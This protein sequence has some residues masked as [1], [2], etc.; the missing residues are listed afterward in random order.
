[1]SSTWQLL[2]R[3]EERAGIR[4]ALTAADSGGIVLTGPAG[5]GKTTLARAV[6]AAL[7]ATVQWVA[8]T[9]SSRSIPLGVFAQW[10]PSS[11][12]R[13]PI[14]LI[15]SAREALL[16]GGDT[17]IGIDDAHLLDQ[18]SA[19]LLHQ[20]ALERSA[21]IIAT[22]RSG[23]AVPD[24]VTSLWKDGH[25]QLLELAPFTKPQ[26]IDLVTRVLGGPLEGLSAD[27]I[28]NASAGNP[29]FLRHMVQG[30]LERGKLREV[31]GFWQLRGD[32]SLSPGLA[33]LLQ[34]RLE[35]AG[36]KAMAALRLLALSEPLDLDLLSQLV[37]EDAVDAAEVEGFLRIVHDGPTLN[38]RIAHPLIGDV[39]RARIG[40]ASARKLRG[41]IVSVL[42]ERVTATAGD[43]IRLAELSIDSDQ[44]TDA[45]LLVSAAKDAL[46]LA[47]LPLAERLARRA[48]EQ[49]GDLPAGELLSRALLWQ[50]RAAEADDVLAIFD[51]A[52][53]GE[54][55]LV[56]WGAPRMSILFWSMG[57]VARARQV[58]AL[59]QQRVTHPALRAV[60]DAIGS[61]MTVHENRIEEGL[62]EASA[63]LADPRSPEQAIDFAAFGCGLALPVAGRGA[64]F[65]PI[66]ARCGSERKSTDG[67]IHY[68]IRYGLVL[69]RVY[70]GE[71]DAADAEVAQCERF[72]SSGQ[73]VGW[74]ITKIAAGCVAIYRG[75]F[76][77]A[78][79]CLEQA[80][81]ALNAEVSMPWRL[82]GRLFLTRAY[83]ALGDIDQAER[84]LTDTA[85]HAGPHLA[86]HD[87][88]AG[89]ARAWL[90]AA[91]GGVRTAIDLAHGA[92]NAAHR[93]GQYALEAEALHHA[94]R[95]GDRT[96]ATRLA[97]LTGRV[98]GGVVHLQARHAAAVAA[99]DAAALD[100]VSLDFE[101]AGFSLS[102]ADAAAQAAAIWERAGDRRGNARSASR[103]L[104][105]AA[106]CGGAVTP[107]IR[108]AAH[109]LPLSS[110]EREIAS[111]VAEGLQNRAIADRLSVSV[112]TVEGHIYRACIKLDVSDREGLAEVIRCELVR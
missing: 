88:H 18:L 67:M 102:A 30:A 12:A 71:L 24:A 111:L 33:A 100:A 43:R 2:D 81:A 34:G 95:F 101:D 41:R 6:T 56:L 70:V 97:T 89:V 75:R 35:H 90:A 80:L 96:A 84:V 87:P 4:A 91:R 106:L 38:A 86:L 99:A 32:A 15:S 40:T 49:R 109:P 110:R 27:V 20:I 74:A 21:R 47:N 1:M 107:A 79:S 82:V 13:D 108:S 29:L 46:F 61:A 17:V 19:T 36:R 65:E 22:V 14:A 44:D 83:A 31:D 45:G 52:T 58:L 26:C 104:R 10:V 55:E 16:A 76:P 98:D 69:A 78:V 72:S 77:E 7:P 51:P 103:A 25:V 53:L 105:L 8:C 63:V 66:A 37:G 9:E 64:D 94:A 85:E 112:R 28:W 11:A 23:E 62:A 57:D 50:G 93:S 48:F 60:V 73:F 42:S 3:S 39:V 92:A 59:L 54:W 5:V 68:M